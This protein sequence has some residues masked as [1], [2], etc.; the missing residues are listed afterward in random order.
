[1]EDE[2]H[3]ESIITFSEVIG[4][5]E[6]YLKQEL[7]NLYKG[8]SNGEKTRAEEMKLKMELLRKENKHLR[9]CLAKYQCKDGFDENTKF[10]HIRLGNI[11]AH[12]GL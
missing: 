2:I 12:K 10:D 8:L 7:D 4:T 6:A 5:L 11:T 3:E 1:M 9:D